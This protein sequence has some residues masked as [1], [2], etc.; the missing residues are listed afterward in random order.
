VRE[1][2]GEDEKET[3]REIAAVEQILCYLEAEGFSVAQGLGILER[4]KDA[5]QMCSYC[6]AGKLELRFGA[7]LRQRD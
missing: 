1:R 7:Y 2:S 6:R 3:A 5:V 4:S